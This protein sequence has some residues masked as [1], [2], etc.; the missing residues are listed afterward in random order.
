MGVA[1]ALFLGLIA[2]VPT[3]PAPAPK[4]VKIHGVKFLGSGCPRGLADVTVDATGT[5]FKATF[6]KFIVQTGP[7]TKPSDW[8]KNCKLTI[9]IE[10]DSGYQFS[11]LETSVKGFA[12][13]PK[14][15]KGHYDNTFSFT[16]QK[17]QVNFGFDLMGKYEGPF[18]LQSNPAIIAWSP[19]SGSTAILNM[20]TQYSLSPAH[21]PAFIT[22]DS[23]T[24]KL[25]VEF[26]VQWQYCMK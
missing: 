3:S 2:A 23:L 15:A 11:I 5:L 14:Y 20:N 24:G 6:S 25:T 10:F 26:S 19:C 1:K 7:R 8:R 13:I 12:Q 9:N 21:L 16:G 18:D 17:E 22:V 4:K